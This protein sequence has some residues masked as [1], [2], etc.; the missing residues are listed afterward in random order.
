[1]RIGFMAA[2]DPERIKFLKRNGFGC[3][4]LMIKPETEYLPGHDGWQDKAA[5][6]RTEFTE[7]GIRISCIAG[8]YLN[9]MDA[10]AAVAKRLHEHVRNTITLAHQ[11]GVK[12]VAGFAGRIMGQ[13]LEESLPKFKEIWSGHAKFAEDNGV[14]IAFEHCPMGTYNSTFGPRAN[15]CICTP[16]MWERCFNEVPSSALGLEWD[17]SHLVCMLIDPIENLR[18]WGSKVFHVHAKDAKINWDVVRR[19][20]LY[21]PDAT[22]HCFVSL[23]DTNWALAVKELIRV[24]YDNDLNVEGWHDRVYRD[25]EKTGSKREDLGLRM[26]LRYLSP[27]VDG[28]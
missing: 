21:H 5:K 22:E 2:H 18:T 13:P 25:D 14:K 26:S 3:V 23:G 11:L 8:F 10:D 28:K 12:V 17:A 27:F 19:H 15:N 4:E 16:A 20:G 6:V 7:A 24:G 9:H 1:M